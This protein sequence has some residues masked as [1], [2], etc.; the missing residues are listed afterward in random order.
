MAV[1][2]LL[3]LRKIS[4][5]ADFGEKK[6]FVIFFIPEIADLKD[7]GQFCIKLKTKGEIEFSIQ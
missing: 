4:R 1:D 3:Y 2:L 7:F 5:I 6:N